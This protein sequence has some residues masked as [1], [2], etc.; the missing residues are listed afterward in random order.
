M[1]FLAMG[2]DEQALRCLNNVAD[3]PE[4]YVGYFSLMNLKANAF[5]YP[6]LEEPRFREVRDRL[7]YQD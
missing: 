5:S 4:P 7:G 2:D 1:G 3:S 6:V